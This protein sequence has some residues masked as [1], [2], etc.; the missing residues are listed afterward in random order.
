MAGQQHF[1]SETAMNSVD[2]SP[3]HGLDSET[4]LCD[5]GLSE[6]DKRLLQELDAGDIGAPSLDEVE[7]SLSDLSQMVEQMED[8]ADGPDAHLMVTDNS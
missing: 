6:E 4:Q 7:V 3:V 5:E 1:A 2:A 8:D